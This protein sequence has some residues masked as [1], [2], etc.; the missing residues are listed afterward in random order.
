[1][2]TTVAIAPVRKT[3]AVKAPIA[4]AFDVFTAGLTSWWPPGHGI[5][6]RPI[7]KVELEPRLGGRW[8]ETAADG[9]ETVVATIIA[10]DR[11]RRFVLLWQVNARWQ[12]DATMRSE[13]ELRFT[14]EDAA[15][16]MVSLVHHKLETLGPEDGAS[17]RTDVARGWPIRLERFAAAAE[18]RDLPPPP[19]C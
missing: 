1:M 11:P 14:A 12:P 15:T 16:T 6:P 13:V 8:L 2:S 17:M 3:I 10:W 7:E 18:G 19:P 4:H 9:T 5:G